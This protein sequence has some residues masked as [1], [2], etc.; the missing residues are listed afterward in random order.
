MKKQNTVSNV[1]ISLKI[2]SLRIITDENPE[3]MTIKK[4]KKVLADQLYQLLTRSSEEDILKLI[5]EY[6]ILNINGVSHEK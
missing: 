3:E 6:K 1:S 2:K 4:W 5:S